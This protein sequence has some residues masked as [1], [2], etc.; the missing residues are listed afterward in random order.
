MPHRKQLL[1]PHDL[2]LYRFRRNTLALSRRISP[3]FCANDTQEEGYPT[4][5]GALPKPRS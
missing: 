5:W 2:H 4:S 3:P 1:K